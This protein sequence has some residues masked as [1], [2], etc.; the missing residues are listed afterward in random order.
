ML[1]TQEERGKATRKAKKKSTK[2]S[3]GRAKKERKQGEDAKVERE[4]SIRIA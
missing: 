2:K 3:K 1:A 4:K